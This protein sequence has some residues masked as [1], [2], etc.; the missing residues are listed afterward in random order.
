LTLA[1]PRP[2]LR[3][4]VVGAAAGVPVSVQQDL[5]AAVEAGDAQRTQALLA[6]GASANRFD[7]LGRTP[8]IVAIELRDQ[9][10]RFRDVV[11]VLL[12]GGARLDLKAFDDCTPLMHA[13]KLGHADVCEILLD[14]GAE[15][16]LQ[17]LKGRTALM[18]AANQLREPVLTLLLARGA[19]HALVDAGGLTALDFLK[20]RTKEPEKI[21]RCVKLLTEA[22][23]R[24]GTGRKASARAN[25]LVRHFTADELTQSRHAP[26]K[27]R[28]LFVFAIVFSLLAVTVL[29]QG[30]GL[31]LVLVVVAWAWLSLH[32]F[33]SI[34]QLPWLLMRSR[35]KGAPDV[36]ALPTAGATEEPE[37]GKGQLDA[38]SNF[39][40][41]GWG[42]QVQLARAH[43]VRL[44]HTRSHLA[45]IGLALAI[46]LV[47]AV[48]SLLRTGIAWLDALLPAA[49]TV[50]TLFQE[51][52]LRN[53][54]LKAYQ[55]AWDQVA[56]E[57][58][59]TLAQRS[60]RRSPAED[61]A[62]VLYLRTFGV[63]GQL[64]IGG[65]DFETSMAYNLTPMMPMIALGHPGE[66]LGAGR[67]LTTDEHWREEILRLVRN[68]TRIMLI[69]SHRD[70]TKWEIARLKEQD[71]FGKTIFAMP[72]EIQFGAGRYSDEWNRAAAA[73]TSIG[74]ALPLHYASGLLFKLG[75]D[76]EIVDH[77]PLQA[78]Q[79]ILEL[80]GLM[81]Q[82]NNNSDTGDDR[83]PDESDDVD[84]D[85]D[86]GA[87][88]GG[89]AGGGDGGGEGGGGGGGGSDGS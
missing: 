33:P 11:Q 66:A 85:G 4:P 12:A 35:G 67:I 68:A 44:T 54:R 34:L 20:W 36:P 42:A 74:L 50:I 27:A 24:K 80:A 58:N 39:M 53:A 38:V 84:D 48:L 37:V 17:N 18:I 87:D 46:L 28:K 62:F 21:K 75:P 23:A 14:A 64:N 52:R 49:V 65:V 7:R 43:K 31:P 32:A 69:P 88:D 79:F 78:Q 5:F 71:H 83:D 76:G 51:G 63:T 10:T 47:I 61:E 81:Q 56:A 9:A 15:L 70:G 59:Q 16:N 82:M 22:G 3:A 40:R 57:I 30:P 25:R 41:L 89:D 6:A 72:P 86:D 19:S 60:A 13:A 45:S 29:K 8:L 2:R 26:L 77:A 1:A 73:L 55:A